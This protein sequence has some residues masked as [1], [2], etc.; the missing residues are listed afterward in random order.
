MPIG[1]LAVD[2][3]R[4][5]NPR[6]KPVQDQY[7]AEMVKR[8]TWLEK[9]IRAKIIDDGFL[10]GSPVTNALI[11][12]AYDY[13]DKT[14][15]VEAFMKWLAE[16]EDE[17]IL[18]I[19]RYEGRRTVVHTGWQDIYVKR[20]YSKGVIWAQEKM[21]D[22]GIAPPEVDSA[23]GAILAGPTHADALG[24]MYIRNF[25]ELKGITE[26]M[27]QQISRVLADG[28]SQGKNPRAIASDIAGRNG[29][30][31]K[32]GLTRA[33]TLARTETARALDE[34]S[35]NRYTDYKVET[36]EWIYSGGNCPSNVC[37]NGDGTQ[38]EIAA[39]HGV[40]PAH[41]NCACAWGPVV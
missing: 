38:Y 33:R 29:R 35:L 6:L 13:P 19:I 11:A 17:G 10:G 36:V 28:L 23:I 39:A 26:A 32:V 20:S 1:S 31:S 25:T 12:N 16:Q 30:V 27:D 15:K 37:P 22:L 8:F 2:A 40:L 24:M 3:T 34:A 18:E 14:G 21:R 7:E 41:P 5:I 4:E 9:Q